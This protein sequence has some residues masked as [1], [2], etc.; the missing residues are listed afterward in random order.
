[1]AFWPAL[2]M[3]RS[4]S[5][6]W[7]VRGAL[8]GGAVL[9]AEVALLSQSRGSLYATPVMLVLVF[10]LLPQRTRTFALFVPVAIGIAAAAPAVLRVGDH[11]RNG[12]VVPATLHSATTAMFVAAVAVGLVVAAGCGR[13]E[14]PGVLGGLRAADSQGRR[15]DRDRHAAWRCWR[16]GWWPRATPSRGSGMAGT[17][18]R[19]ATPPTAP[20]RS[21]LT[22]GLGSNRYDFYRVAPER[23]RRTSAVRDRR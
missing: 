23:V 13:R 18:S 6:P 3:A 16:A 7:G 19:P 9:L 1:M 8:A 10:A 2:L 17:P 21:R 5:L 12:A 14:P 20:A 4:R 15:R 22:S 11:L